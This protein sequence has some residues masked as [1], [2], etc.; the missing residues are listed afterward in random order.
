M[1]RAT[2][3]PDIDEAHK[4][5]AYTTSQGR[6]REPK[7][8]RT[9]RYDLAWRLTSEADHVL[10]LTATPH[11]GDEDRFAHFLRLVDP[12]VFPEPHRLSEEAAK[13]RRDVF[14]LGDDCQWALRRLKEDLRDMEGKRLFPDRHAHTVTFTLST[15]EF[16]LYK[17]VTGYINEFMPQQTGRRRGSAA[18]AR[19]VFQRRIASSTRAIHESLERR[20]KK[21][22]DLLDELEHL[23]PKQR[24]KRLAVLQGLVTDAEMDDG[25]LDDEMCDLLVDEYSAAV[26]LDQIRAEIAAL[27]EIAERARRVREQGPEADSKLRALMECLSRAEFDE[28]KDGRGKLLIFTEHRSTLNHVREHLQTAGYT[29]CEIHGSMNPRQRKHAQE[30]F[31]THAQICVATEAAGEGI[32]LQFCHLMVNYDLPWNPTLLEQR[33]GRI[34]RIG[35]ERDCYAFNFV[36]VESEEGDPIIEGR[37]LHRL[38]EK[39]DQMNEAL[40]G[41]VFDVIGEGSM[42]G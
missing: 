35:Q 31:R 42:S 32:N 41:R 22:Q 23:S 39:L 21:Q 5:S 13:I 37:I 18:L 36:A 26:E 20:L 38:L 14:R 27:K 4:C 8:H 6:D 16:N 9:K 17:E 1:R 40:D 30:V 19:T 34:H 3:T 2:E 7:V 29:T 28:L 10:L 24:S 11:H 12:D 25:D 15:D 33:L